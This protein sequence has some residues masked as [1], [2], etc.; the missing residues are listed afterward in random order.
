MNTDKNN[1]YIKNS[2][3]SS[4]DGFFEIPYLSNSPQVMMESI[5]NL[6][7]ATHNKTTQKVHTE[8]DFF[9]GN[10]NYIE[11]EEGLWLFAYNFDVKQN[12]IA[13]AFY[14][15]HV[16]ADYFYLT[17]SVFEYELPVLKQEKNIVLLSKCW[18]LYRPK[19][20]V[21]M[22]FYKNTSGRFINFVFNKK[23][24]EANICT[25]FPA[26]TSFFNAKTGYLTW[27][28]QVPGEHDLFEAIYKQFLST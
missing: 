9:D 18:T 19:T 1:I 8:N 16:P 26:L 13:N 22:Y 3:F 24:A 14:D 28:D 27:L 21:S 2:L 5:I 25:T 10:M 6:P 17:L 12:I 11:V 4:K 15:D 20:M 7:V 23:W